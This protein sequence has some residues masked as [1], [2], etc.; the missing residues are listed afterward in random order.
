MDFPGTVSLDSLPNELLLAVFSYFNQYELLTCISSGLLE[1]SQ[2][3]LPRLTSLRVPQCAWITDPYLVSLM[4]PGWLVDLDVTGCYRLFGG[5]PRSL[6]LY[7]RMDRI[8]LLLERH[9]P[10][11]RRL[12]L[13]SVLTLPLDRRESTS[14]RLD[15]LSSIPQSLPHLTYLDLSDNRTLVQFFNSLSKSQGLLAAQSFWEAFCSEPFNTTD[16]S[17]PKLTLVLGRWPPEHAIIFAEAVQEM[18]T[19]C[20]CLPTLC[21][22]DQSLVLASLSLSSSDL[23]VHVESIMNTKRKLKRSALNPVRLESHTKW[24]G[25]VE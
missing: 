8:C 14:T 2:I 21:V 10:S 4:E 11:L 6:R 9:C 13:A 7:E 5:S 17:K 19:Q 22:D 23:V 3:Q 16:C 25:R 12:S 15:L 20:Q 18:A 1:L 24:S